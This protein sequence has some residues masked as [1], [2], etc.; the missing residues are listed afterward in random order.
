MAT[1]DDFFLSK[2]STSSAINIID[3]SWSVPPENSCS[4]ETILDAK[5]SLFVLHVET[6]RLL[7]PPCIYPGPRVAEPYSLQI[8]EVLHSTFNLAAQVFHKGHKER[9]ITFL[10]KC[11]EDGKLEVLFVFRQVGLVLL[12]EVNKIEQVTVGESAKRLRDFQ[13]LLQLV[14][15]CL[16]TTVPRFTPSDK[17]LLNMLFCKQRTA[18]DMALGGISV[19]AMPVEQRN[20]LDELICN[21]KAPYNV[22]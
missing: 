22:M 20:I 1:P 19:L 3:K 12:V 8:G 18:V 13:T 11:T 9:D 6:G 14:F 5:R 7:C 4:L 2:R 21:V 15:G 10:R 16:Q 17:I